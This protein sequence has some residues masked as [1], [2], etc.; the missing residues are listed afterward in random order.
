MP[1]PDAAPREAQDDLALLRSAAAEAG[2]IAMRYFGQRP[3]VWMK[4]GDSPVSEA[5]YAADAYLRET[6]TAAR[7]DYGWLSEESADDPTR[8]GRSRLFV[9]D[10]IDGTRGFLDGNKSWCVSVAVVENGMSRVGVLDCPAAG[11]HFWATRGGG[12]WM[13]GAP[14]GIRPEKDSGPLEIGGPRVMFERLPEAWKSRSSRVAYVPSLAYR[15][16]L[17][18]SGRLDATFV[19]PNAHDWDIAAASLLLDEAGGTLLAA[20]G[21]A[22]RYGADT[23]V[24]GALAAGSGVLLDAMVR[25]LAEYAG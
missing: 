19:K 2:R 9:V 25:V 15:L 6:L 16:A 3:E 10:P 7:P 22:P 13:N 5:D 12:A 11:E 14:I 20:G 17:I 24:H 8:H 21:A 18:A 4:S 1:E 23:A